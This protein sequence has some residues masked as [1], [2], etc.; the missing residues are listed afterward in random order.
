VLDSYAGN[1]G[2]SHGD[3]RV[4]VGQRLMQPASELFFG[5]TGRHFYLRQLR[6]IKL[7]PIIEDYD[8]E[9]LHLHAEVCAWALARAHARSGDPAMI[10]GYLGSN[11]TFDDSMREFAV[12]YADQ[13]LRDYRT[14]GRAVRDGR[15]EVIIEQ[16]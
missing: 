1:R 6:D 2:H 5:W 16:P 8:A 15:M 7:S 3:R 12:K 10:A 11:S 14:F 9:R 13:N 4:V